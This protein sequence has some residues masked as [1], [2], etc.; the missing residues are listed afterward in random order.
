VDLYIHS[1]IHLY[2]AGLNGVKHRNF[3][4]YFT[5]VIKCLQCTYSFQPHY[6]PG[7]DTISNRN[8]YEKIFLGSKALPAFKAENITVHCEPIA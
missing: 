3:T 8:E 1:S 5:E 4:F 2:G 7:V 6:G